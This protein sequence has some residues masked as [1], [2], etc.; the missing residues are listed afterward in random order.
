MSLR[1]ALERWERWTEEQWR[2][3]TSG[4]DEEA[5][6]DVRPRFAA[7]SARPLPQVG[8]RTARQAG[9][10]ASTLGW[11]QSPASR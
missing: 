3:I 4:R 5:Y 7:P 10:T 1:G 8:G 6:E 11:S 2:C 9:A